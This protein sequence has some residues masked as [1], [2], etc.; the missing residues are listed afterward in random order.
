MLPGL[1]AGSGLKKDPCS[2]CVLGKMT[3]VSI[4]SV[5]CFVSKLW[6]DMSYNGLHY[7]SDWLSFSQ[8]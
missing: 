3:K 7:L 4:E 5:A 2:V 6:R 8:Y 1:E